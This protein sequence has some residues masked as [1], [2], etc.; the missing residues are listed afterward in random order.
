[1]QARAVVSPQMQSQARP[2]IMLPE[3]WI[4]KLVSNSTVQR[5]GQRRRNMLAYAHTCTQKEHIKNRHSSN[6]TPS[7]QLVETLNFLPLQL[8]LCFLQPQGGFLQAP[9]GWS[10]LSGAVTQSLIP[11]GSLDPHCPLSYFFH[12]YSFP[13]DIKVLKN[14]SKCS[15]SQIE[16]PP[17]HMVL[18]KQVSSQ[19][20][21]QPSLAVVMG[22]PHDTSDI[23][24][25]EFL[26]QLGTYSSLQSWH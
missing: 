13:L 12:C 22:L 20:L 24:C 4:V 2:N 15:G 17:T 7:L 9:A 16:L 3:D 26:H 21:T 6:S 23:E 10:P 19:W 25:V 5:E 14:N 18:S 1:M 11:K 8:L